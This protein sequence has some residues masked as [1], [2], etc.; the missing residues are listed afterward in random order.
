MLPIVISKSELARELGCSAPNVTK[1]IARGLPV[2]PDGKIDLAQAC[3]WIVANVGDGRALA[4][5]AEFLDLLAR[6]EVP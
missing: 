2:M 1:L 5:A 4:H 6:P 3:R